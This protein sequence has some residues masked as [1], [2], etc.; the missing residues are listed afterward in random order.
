MIKVNIT[1]VA[2][3]ISCN[4]SLIWEYFWTLCYQVKSKT[5]NRLSCLTWSSL[6]KYACECENMSPSNRD[7]WTI[8]TFICFVVTLQ[9][10]SEGII[11]PHPP[12]PQEE[13]CRIYKTGERGEVRGKGT[14]KIWFANQLEMLALFYVK[15]CIRSQS[16]LSKD[17]PWVS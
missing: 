6:A 10:R 2:T 9:W 5:T 17:I 7:E 16:N 13:F 15:C 4:F 11:P 8:M 1:I 12:H 14:N 3:M